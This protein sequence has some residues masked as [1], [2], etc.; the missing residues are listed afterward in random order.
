MNLPNKL[1]TM[2]MILIPIILILYFIPLFNQNVSFMNQTF[3]VNELV[4][5]F[6][7][8]VA[9][10]TDLL[11]GH[12]A[13]KHQ[14]ITTFGKFMDPIA[15]K[16]LVN[17]MFFLFVVGDR[18]HPILFLLMFFRDIIV[19]GIRMLAASKG[20]VIAAGNLGKL[21][22]VLQMFSIIFLS[23]KNIP[24]EQLNIPMAQI[25]VIAASVVSVISGLQYLWG[26]KDLILES[27]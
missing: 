11:D 26:A 5:L 22:T 9:S 19:D 14:L 13:R 25:L 12:I 10:I 17:S 27:I 21:K 6:F 8:L 1:T 2:R 23:L 20:T 18:I 16:L 4:I 24:F 15:D 3:S 7:F